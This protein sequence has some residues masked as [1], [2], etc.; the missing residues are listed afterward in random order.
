MVA[1]KISGKNQTPLLNLTHPIDE[2]PVTLPLQRYDLHW[3]VQDS[4][5]PPEAWLKGE[6]KLDR[7]LPYLK[8]ATPKPVGHLKAPNGSRQRLVWDPSRPLP[9]LHH[10]SWNPLSDDSLVLLG[11]NEN[12]VG[13][14]ALLPQEAVRL[15]GGRTEL[16]PKLPPEELASHLLFSTP[17][18]LAAAA[19]AWLKQEEAE[20]TCTPLTREG[21]EDRFDP[22]D[23]ARCR[24]GVCNLPWEEHTK[25]ALMSWLEQRGYGSWR[26]SEGR[27]GGSG[28]PNPKG[29]VK[30]KKGKGKGKGKSPRAQID[31]AVTRILRHEGAWE[32]PEQLLSEEGWLPVNALLDLLAK[33]PAGSQVDLGLP[34]LQEL[35][36]ANS[37]KRFILRQ[38]EATGTWH[39]AAWSGHTLPGV[40][41]PGVPQE[42]PDTL[43]HGTYKARVP[44]IQLSGLLPFRRAI[45]FQDPKSTSGRWRS[46]LEV[47]CKVNM[48]KAIQ[49]GCTFRLTGNSI[50]LTSSSPKLH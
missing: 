17:P 16:L 25:Q 18:L 38:D 23:A 48:A 46:D 41:G 40:V 7:S 4:K 35:E 8:S 29:K 31:H 3:K 9:A 6:L 1:R 27:V 34:F 13:T 11:A 26:E 20:Q 28:A 33:E 5:A 2:E 14:R 15:L 32:G 45:H 19:V 39:A 12:G 21:P 47:A 42:P 24:S 50:W 36:A 30:G 44:S 49:E 43:L 22:G 10:N 37:K